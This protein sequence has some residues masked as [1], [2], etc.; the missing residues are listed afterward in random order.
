VL[1]FYLDKHHYG[2]D[3]LAVK[4]INRNI[5]YTSVPDAPP[6]IVG[7][8]NMR[9]QIVTLFDLA[10]MMGLSKTAEATRPT[11]VILKNT[12][13]NPDYIGF[14]IDSPGEVV[15]I[16]TDACEPP[17]PNASGMESKFVSEVVKLE[18]ALL[19]LLNFQIIL[20]GDS[21]A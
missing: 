3:I 19:M 11:C 13:S 8:L 17:P 7:L 4:E 9:G 21:N 16:N 1:T 2:I 15:D 14:L 20:E 18:S 10:A 6:H 12:S 5:E